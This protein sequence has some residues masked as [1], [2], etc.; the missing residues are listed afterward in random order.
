[1]AVVIKITLKAPFTSYDILITLSFVEPEI[2]SLVISNSDNTDLLKG[3]RNPWPMTDQSIGTQAEFLVFSFFLSS[4]LVF[5][6]KKK[7]AY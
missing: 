6:K 4:S 1:M 2:G 5:P 7:S 3:T